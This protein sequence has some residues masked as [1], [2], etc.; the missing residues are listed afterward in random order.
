[1]P[2]GDDLTGADTGGGV[3]VPDPGGLEDDMVIVCKAV[4]RFCRAEQRKAKRHAKC[5]QSAMIG[6]I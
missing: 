6:G 2:T 4:T 1:L 3:H 5:G